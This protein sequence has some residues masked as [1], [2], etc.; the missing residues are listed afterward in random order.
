MEA[1]LI[2]LATSLPARECGLKLKLRGR[3]Y[4][5]SGVTPRAGVW[6]ETLPRLEI[7]AK[8]LGHS[9]RGSVD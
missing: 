1:E 2:E 5:R 7:S 6:I 3:T 9:P 8:K 4:E